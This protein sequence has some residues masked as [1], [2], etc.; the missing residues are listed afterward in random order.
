MLYASQTE[1]KR[2]DDTDLLQGS[3]TVH[4]MLQCLA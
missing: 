2:S 1:K 3:L 4:R